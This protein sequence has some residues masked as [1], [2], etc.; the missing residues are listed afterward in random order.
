MD[1]EV[2]PGVVPSVLATLAAGESIY[3]EHGIVLYKED[4]VKV[5]RK[6]IPSSGM[7][8]TLKR[9]TVGGLPFYLAEFTGPGH[10]AFS[11][12]GV[13]EVR[14]MELGQNEVLD[15]AEG[16]LVCAENRLR[17]ETLYVKG[18]PG[19][20]GMWMDQL[21]GPG[22]FALHA[23]GNFITMRLA[24]GESVVCERRAILHKTPTMPIAPMI[25]KVGK[26]LLGRMMAQEM[27]VLQGPGTI[28]LQTGR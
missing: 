20:G 25:Q 7:F 11:R 18:L 16:S 23:Y 14:V 17:Y 15:V 1:L 13:G 6:N 21:A 5:D 12:D 2:V 28:G 19:W 26:G 9:T 24:P 22:K 27:Y 4:S 8:S 3:S 10:A